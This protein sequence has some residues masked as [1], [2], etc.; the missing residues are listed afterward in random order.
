MTTPTWIW[1][2]P[3]WPAFH[4]RAAVIRPRL[5]A[6]WRSLGMLL[7]RVGSLPGDDDPAVTLDTLLQ[8]IITSSAIEGERLNAAS[9]RSSLARRLGVE[10]EMK[11]VSSR[12][13]GLADMMMDAIGSPDTVLTRERLFQWHRWLFPDGEASL[14]RLRVGEWRGE[15]PMQVVSGRLDKPKVHFEAPPR[16]VLGDEMAAFLAWFDASRHDPTLDP[17]LRAGI[18][19]FWFVTLHPFED[20]NGRLARAIA[21]RAL[22]QADRQS[23]RLYTMSAAILAERQDYYQVLESSQRGT[24]D[25]SDWLAWFL[26]ILLQTLEDALAGIERTLAKTR[27]W[28]QFAEAG[29]LPEQVK[30]LNRLLEGGERGFEGGISAAQYQKVAKVSKATATRHLSDL[31][32][33]GCLEKLP[34]GGR[35]TRYQVVGSGLPLPGE[36]TG[37]FKPTGERP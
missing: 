3:D 27:F 6:A 1:Q 30:V 32:A 31:L 23:I 14:V 21:D 8:N 11:A 20:G 28:Q 19:H 24:T 15:E 22:A 34:G 9:V 2:Q 18:A 16:A 35:S 7:G 5:Q 26:D 12:S 13:E 4:W 29:L 10:G 36:R 33:K 17:L 37:T 25:L